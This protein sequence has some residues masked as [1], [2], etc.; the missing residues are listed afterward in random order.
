MLPSS[1]HQSSAGR[2]PARQKMMTSLFSLCQYKGAKPGWQDSRT[3]MSLL[4]PE[5]LDCTHNAAYA[6]ST[7][8]WGRDEWIGHP[9]VTFLITQW[10]C[11]GALFLWP[12]HTE[13]VTRS[14]VWLD[15][16]TSSPALPPAPDTHATSQ[17]TGIFLYLIHS[18][19]CLATF[20]WKAHWRSAEGL[21]S[22]ID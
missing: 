10:E 3:G 17:A 18:L 7:H 22:L 1:F 19:W 12:T 2:L 4:V 15:S 20:P 14:L 5:S 21:H 9:I 6:G 11:K 13:W 16:G 8:T